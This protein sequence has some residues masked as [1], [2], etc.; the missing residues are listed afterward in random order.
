MF[1]AGT[2]LDTGS[3]YYRNDQA[4]YKCLSYRSIATAIN[5]VVV[6][7]FLGLAMAALLSRSYIFVNASLSLKV[8][9]IAGMALALVD[10]GY[11]YIR[12]KSSGQKTIEVFQEKCA[13]Q[14]WIE[15]GKKCEEYGEQFKLLAKEKCTTKAEHQQWSSKAEA[16]RLE[17][18]GYVQAIK[19]L[20]PS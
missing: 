15:V 2:Y 9:L 18:L 7:A 4:D 14:K 19:V 13:R 11:L 12:P 20:F 3:L 8:T 6:G 1:I 17:A 5:I 10:G 16:L